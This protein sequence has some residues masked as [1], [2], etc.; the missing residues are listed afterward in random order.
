M[1]IELPNVQKGSYWHHLVCKIDETII[2]SI[3]RKLATKTANWWDFRAKF[4]H[5]LYNPSLLLMNWL[6]HPKT[7]KNKHIDPWPYISP[8]MFIISVTV[9]PSFTKHFSSTYCSNWAICIL[10]NW[11]QIQSS[12]QTKTKNEPI[13]NLAKWAVGAGVSIWRC[14]PSHGICAITVGKP[15]PWFS[16]HI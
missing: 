3:P 2:L 16:N 1:K 6:D 8:K 7:Y 14:L 9:F 10:L 13:R 11:A 12:P 4:R 15:F 5:S